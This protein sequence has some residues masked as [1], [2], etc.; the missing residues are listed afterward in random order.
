MREAWAFSYFIPIIMLILFLYGTRRNK[1]HLATSIRIL[2]VMAIVAI[3]ANMMM[4]LTQDRFLTMVAN[5]IF[6][7]T[8]TWILYAML[9]YTREY[10]NFTKY[11]KVHKA[12]FMIIL[13]LDSANIMLNCIFEHSYTCYEITYG[14]KSGIYYVVDGL[15]FH[16]VHMVISYGMIV[17]VTFLLIKKITQAPTIYKSKYIAVLGILGFD[18]VCN[19]GYLLLDLPVDPSVT[20]YAVTAACIYYCSFTLSPKRLANRTI[21]QVMTNMSEA[22]LLYDIDGNCV[23]INEAAEKLMANLEK[24]GIIRTR[25]EMYIKW[26]GW[27]EEKGDTANANEELQLFQS[28]NLKNAVLHLKITYQKLQ[29]EKGRFQGSYFTVYD[30]TEEAQNLIKERYNATHDRLTGLY[31]KAY[32]CDVVHDYLK[33]NPEETY[34]MICSDIANFK[35]IN[36]VFDTETGDKLLCRIANILR[37]RLTGYGIY[38]RLE[39]DRFAVVVPKQG[40]VLETY[41]EGIQEFAYVDAPLPYQVDTYIGIYEIQDVS[42]PV[43]MMCDRALMALHTVKGSQKKYAFYDEVLRDQMIREKELSADLDGA[44]RRED[45]RIF[46]Q[47]QVDMDGVAV[48]AEALVRWTHPSKGVII[49]G[50]FIPYLEKSG[51][52][53]KVDRHVW[54]LACRTLKKWKDQGKEQ[55]YISVNISPV[56]FYYLDI[57][58][59]FIE[60]VKKYEISPTSIRL[61]ITESAIMQN[62]NQQVGLISRLR[63]AGF[64]VEMDDFGS[65]YSSLNMLKDLYVDILKLDM[66]F[67]GQAKDM[68]RAR[69]ILSSIVDLA[70][71]LKIPV[72]CEGVETVEQVNFLKGIG[73]ETFQGYYFG[74]PMEVSSFEENFM[75]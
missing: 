37:R 34:L 26:R 52:I 50:D 59:T 44:I 75:K 15:P 25:D 64:I 72:V 35:L 47:P 42:I 49:P 46:L 73:C 39:G 5:S 19:S 27:V 43:S 62:F 18:L 32:F 10:T 55:Y 23:F 2:S 12:I 38:G 28:I 22:A 13:F 8:L 17:L 63:N 65:A 29:D 3:A 45:V 68:D 7:T 6:H 33:A 40:F 30:R 1:T 21:N 11:N 56:D 36:D 66:A 4:F 48:G 71:R 69:E 20:L 74:R 70:K 16:I 54:E 51:L 9:S 58:E 67:L 31:N 24:E 53:A 60:L 41:L 14:P 57:Y 61:E